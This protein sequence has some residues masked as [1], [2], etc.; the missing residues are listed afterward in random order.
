MGNMDK[1]TKLPMYAF[2]TMDGLVFKKNSPLTAMH[3]TNSIL[4]EIQIG[5]MQAA[6]IE[7]YTPTAA[8]PKVA[9]PEKF[10]TK[11]VEKPKQDPHFGASTVTVTSADSPMEQGIQPPKGFGTYAHK[12]VEPLKDQ[13][14]SDQKLQDLVTVP[15][16][17]GSPPV[18]RRRKKKGDQ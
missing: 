10:E 3:I 11:I 13:A 17:E 8:T 18:K 9:D 5:P 12:V 7:P 16:W 2:F 14:P 6:R 15:I 4:G 1:W